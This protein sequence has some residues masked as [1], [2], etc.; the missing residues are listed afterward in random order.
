MQTTKRQ[1]RTSVIERLFA[2]P[3]RFQFGQAVRVIDAWLGKDLAATDVLDHCV[4]F[5]A[6]TSLA[7]PASDIESIECQRGAGDDRQPAAGDMPCIGITPAFMAMLGSTGVL[8]WHYTDSIAAADQRSRDSSHS[9]FFEL[10]SHRPTV[11]FYQAWS[12]SR[13]SYR[14]G[15]DK[16][17]SHLPVALAMAGYLSASPASRVQPTLP[18][19]HAGTLRRHTVTA[20]MLASILSEYFDVPIAV[21]QFLRKWSPLPAEYQTRLGSPH[22]RADMLLTLGERIFEPGRWVRLRIGPLTKAG[23]D[24]FLPG[25]DCA[26]ALPAVLALFPLEGLR[27]EVLLVLRAQDVVP[28]RLGGDP[29]TWPRLGYGT[30][31]ITDPQTA[32]REGFCYELD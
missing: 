6:R 3:Y 21:E 1:P 24:R 10:V 5:R 26:K 12:L 20:Q 4:R 22:F 28:I 17:L 11:L 30:F 8:P 31:C 14:H 18:A 19:M 29:S 16:P 32:D 7:F 2:Q 13:W 23:F 15:G 25:G 9:A 27:F